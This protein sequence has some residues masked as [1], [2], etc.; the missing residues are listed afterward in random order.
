MVIAIC[1]NTEVNDK[2]NLSPKKV[3]MEKPVNKDSTF[4]QW[5]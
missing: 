2:V 5:I 3:V 4:K 1:V